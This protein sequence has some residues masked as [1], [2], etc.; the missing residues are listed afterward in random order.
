MAHHA[1][2]TC[3]RFFKKFHVAGVVPRQL[4]VFADRAF[5]IYCYDC[6]DHVEGLNE[7]RQRR[8]R[9]SFRV[10]YIPPAPGFRNARSIVLRD[11]AAFRSHR[12]SRASAMATAHAKVT[13]SPA[14]DD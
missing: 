12:Q 2:M 14:R 7:V 4:A 11:L 5:P 9:R 1:S 8:A 6:D 10:I 3:S 13:R